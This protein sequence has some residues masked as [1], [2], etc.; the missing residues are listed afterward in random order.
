MTVRHVT[1]GPG[2][3]ARAVEAMWPDVRIWWSVPVEHG[4]FNE[5]GDGPLCAAGSD[6]AL[7]AVSPC[8]ST[9]DLANS[10]KLPTNVLLR[11]PR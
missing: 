3:G 8:G 2:D 9:N 1:A 7:W 10:L 5:T 11:R 6:S 4:T